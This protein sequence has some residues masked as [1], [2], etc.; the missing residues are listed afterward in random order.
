MQIPSVHLLPRTRPL[1]RSSPLLR[2]RHRQRLRGR[3]QQRSQQA[4]W[5]FPAD[6]LVPEIDELIRAQAATGAIREAAKRLGASR[7]YH[8]VGIREAML[9]FN[10]FFESAH[11]RADHESMRDLVEGWA[12]EN[13]RMEP[14]SCTDVRTGLATLAHFE[15]LIY[16]MSLGAAAKRDAATVATLDLEWISQVHPL[17]WTMLADI[18]QTVIPQL[19]SVGATGTLH[20]ARIHVLLERSD[21]GYSALMQCVHGLNSLKAGAV[22]RTVAS[23]TAIPATAGEVTQTCAR[24]RSGSQE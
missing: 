4:G 2:S 6:W 3:W 21:E 16:D 14:F 20:R 12:A 1:I 8:G 15:R 13:E 7:A 23:F 22:G 24:L 5:R 17:N 11:I 10:A 9:D 19:A 18:G